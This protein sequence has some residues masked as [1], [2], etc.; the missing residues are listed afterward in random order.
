MF[1]F[2]VLYTMGRILGL[3]L[4]K[5][6]TVI[7]VCVVFFVCCYFVFVLLFVFRCLCSLFLSLPDGLSVC[8]SG[9]KREEES[10]LTENGFV[11]FL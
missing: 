8:V 1:P 9:S 6:P 2:L 3:R 11:I 5:A 10:G 4:P 7:S